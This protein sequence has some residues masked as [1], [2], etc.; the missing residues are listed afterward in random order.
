MAWRCEYT[1]TFGGEANYSWVRRVTIPAGGE[2]ESQAALMRRAKR[3]LGISGV[4]GRTH[5][6]GDSYELRPYGMCTVA[7]VTWDDWS[8][9]AHDVDATMRASL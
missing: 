4:R 3:A 1:D 9:K 6:Y 7:F 8:D 5:S 2:N